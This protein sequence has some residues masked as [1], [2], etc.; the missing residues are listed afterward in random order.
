MIILSGYLDDK[1]ISIQVKDHKQCRLVQTLLQDGKFDIVGRSGCPDMCTC[2]IGGDCS[3]LP[4][5]EYV[6]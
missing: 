5:V 2:Y 3:F 6:D 1:P 4:G